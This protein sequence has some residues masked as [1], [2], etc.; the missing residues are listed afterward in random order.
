MK[1][2]Q[3]Q[4][5]LLVANDIPKEEFSSEELIVACWKRYPDTFGLKGYEQDYPD[6]NSVSTSIMGSKGLINENL[7]KK[8]SKKIYSVTVTGKQTVVKILKQTEGQ[9][10]VE[11]KINKEI[12]SIER[13]DSD[14]L[15]R[16][17]KTRFWRL[18]I[19]EN[20][21]DAIL[22]DDL[23]DLLQLSSLCTYSDFV[24]AKKNLCRLLKNLD[25]KDENDLIENIPIKNLKKLRICTEKTIEKFNRTWSYLREQEEKKKKKN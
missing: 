11:K 12:I 2:S 17:T 7:L 6:S 20:R 23:M 25:K 22:I 5:I 16:L 1:L 10:G 14:A 21:E 8:I 9:E 24:H 15:K 13:A 3:H 4:Q 19:N 18:L